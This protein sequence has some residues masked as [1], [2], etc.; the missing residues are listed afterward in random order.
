MVQIT[1]DTGQEIVRE[2]KFM[3]VKEKSGNVIWSQGNWEYEEK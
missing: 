2:K 3:K 1:V